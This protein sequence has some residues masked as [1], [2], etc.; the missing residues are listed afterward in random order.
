MLLWACLVLFVVCL[1]FGVGFW[2]WDWLFLGVFCCFWL[3]LAV[4]GLFRA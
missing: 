2:G 1:M 3:L 4:F